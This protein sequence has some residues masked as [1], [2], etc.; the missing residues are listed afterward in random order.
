MIL[1][2][3]LVEFYLMN[4]PIYKLRKVFYIKKLLQVYDLYHKNVHKIFVFN[5]NK[6]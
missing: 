3:D 2:K 4:N 6:F 1:R 5:F